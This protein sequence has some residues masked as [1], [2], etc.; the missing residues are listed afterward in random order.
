ME[1]ETFTGAAPRASRETQLAQGTLVVRLMAVIRFT[2]PAC[3]GRHEMAYAAPGRRGSGAARPRF[4]LVACPKGAPVGGGMRCVV[5]VSERDIE[6]LGAV[7]ERAGRAGTRDLELSPIATQVV[8]ASPVPSSPVPPDSKGRR[9]RSHVDSGSG[10]RAGSLRGGCPGSRSAQS[11]QASSWLY[12]AKA[13]AKASS[14]ARQPTH[15]GSSTFSMARNSLPSQVGSGARPRRKHSPSRHATQG[16][17]PR[18]H[19][20]PPG[21]D[22]QREGGRPHIIWPGVLPG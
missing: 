3:G 9:L 8:A 10:P 18:A 1:D 20:D 7:V 5:Q 13:A 11:S 6:K 4:F 2:C 12:R 19:A 17:R 22:R 16:T 15:G 14:G 21:I